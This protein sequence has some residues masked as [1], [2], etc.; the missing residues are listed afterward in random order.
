MALVIIHANFPENAYS[1]LFFS[2]PVATAASAPAQR[3]FHLCYITNRCIKEF[4][5]S[6]GFKKPD[7]KVSHLRMCKLITVCMVQNHVFPEL[8]PNVPSTQTVQS[9]V[10]FLT[11]FVDTY[12]GGTFSPEYDDGT[13]ISNAGFV[14]CPLQFATSTPR[15]FQ[16]YDV[17]YI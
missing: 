3:W 5:T 9:N 16:K 13:V 10:E 4:L 15:E 2:Q 11:T 1:N 14:M 8:R 6:F 17:S 7:I 12:G